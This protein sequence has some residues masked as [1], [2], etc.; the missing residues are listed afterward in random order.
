MADPVLVPAAVKSFIQGV[1]FARGFLRSNF[2]PIGER[3]IE[4]QIEY[5]RLPADVTRREDFPGGARTARRSP[6]SASRRGATRAAGQS[7]EPIDQTVPSAEP[8][9][10]APPAGEIAQ[11]PPIEAIIDVV[12]S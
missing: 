6:Q 5:T 3:S 11:I 10:P 4:E 2:V 8:I 7:M 1:R 9:P 12:T